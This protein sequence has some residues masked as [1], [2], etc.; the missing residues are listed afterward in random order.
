MDLFI[1]IIDWT[2]LFFFVGLNTS[3]FILLA[4]SLAEIFL[5]ARRRIAADLDGSLRSY[6]THPV[7]I[8]APAFNERLTIEGSVRALL[9]LRYPEFEVVV[10]NDGSTDRTVQV[11]IEAF[12]M[13]EV[14]P[15]Y[16]AVIPTR[17][18][19]AIYKSHKEPK[20]TLIDKANGGKADALNCGINAARF[21]LFCSI[22]ADTLITPDALLRLALPFIDDPARTIATGGTVRVANGC[23]IRNGQ[24]EAIGMPAKAVP[25]F[26]VVEY[27]RAFLFGR[28]GWN[29]LGGTLIISGAFGLFSRDAVLKVQGY[30]HD[31]VGEDMELVVRLHR[32]MREDQVPYRIVFVWDSTCYTEVPESLE[33]LGRQRDRWHRGLI[34]SIW[35]HRT[36]FF[37]PRYG[38]VGMVIFPFFAI[39][40]MLGP[41][42]ELLGLVTVSISYLLGIVDTSFMLLF[43]TVSLIF[44]VLLSVA[45]LALE[46]ISFSVYPNWRD[47]LR[48]AV[49]GVVE[50]FGYRQ[51]TLYWRLRGM[52]NYF[53]GIQAWGAMSRRGFGES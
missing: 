26:Q 38:V 36:M 13:Y 17:P 50:N 16:Q 20:L 44:G 21:P 34:D 29:L 18:V 41:I 25:A 46:E 47:L 6:H 4:L 23:T 37:N 52:V 5:R 42:V 33:Q 24:V 2:F 48:M 14:H 15:I 22:D 31:T 40:E 27:L 51:L 35:R 45:T 30:R 49:F 10:V 11:M 28:V 9:A 7:S 39:F 19:I 53:R 3:Y 12:D 8:I 1:Y 32:Q 43:L